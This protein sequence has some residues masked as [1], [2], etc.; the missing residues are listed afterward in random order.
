MS[1]WLKHRHRVYSWLM[2]NAMKRSILKKYRACHFWHSFTR[3]AADETLSFDPLP[4]KRAWN[5]RSRLFFLVA[6]MGFEPHDLRV[7]S[8]TSYQTA[9]PRDVTNFSIPPDV[10]SVKLLFL[11]FLADNRPSHRHR[12]RA[13]A[14]RRSHAAPPAQCHSPVR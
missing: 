3:I 12:K 6:G 2:N 10:S 9:L 11:S 1:I 4:R 5:N 13:G 8:P 14:W 7:M